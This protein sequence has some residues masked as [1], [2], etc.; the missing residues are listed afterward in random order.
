MDMPHVTVVTVVRNLVEADRVDTFRQCVE[1]VRGQSWPAVEHLVVDGASTDGTLG[2]LDAYAKRGF[3][4]YRSAPD[5][6][7][8]DA[9]NTGLGLAPGEFVTF[10]NSDDFYHDPR[11]LEQSVLA[12]RR[13]D[14]DCSYAP[15]RQ[16]DPQGGLNEHPARLGAALL[17]MPFCHQT[18]VYKAASLR[19]YPFH[20]D[21]SIAADYE[22][23]LRLLLD[24]RRFCEVPL[25]GVTFRYG[26]N[27]SRD[28]TR[29][30]TDF[31]KVHRSLYL[32]RG[33]NLR[34]CERLLHSHAMSRS[35]FQALLASIA[36]EHRSLF[37]QW[38]RQDALRRLKHWLVT[39]KRREGRRSLRILGIWF[40]Q[41]S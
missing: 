4:L 1:S 39:W 23:V 38:R 27:S 30:N 11:F 8:Y 34:Q 24:G 9:M 12:L 22:Q 36:P 5:R 33:M 17:H 2:I 10:L 28:I 25:C 15:V 3:V 20:A 21:F 40:A 16:L 26:G 19:R 37:E 32:S 41:D 35:V 29:S 14:A 6:G 13:T 31:T 18:A 7:V